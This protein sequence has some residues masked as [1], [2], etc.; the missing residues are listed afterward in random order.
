MYFFTIFPYR[1]SGKIKTLQ[2]YWASMIILIGIFYPCTRSIVCFSRFSRFSR[3]IANVIDPTWC[4]CIWRLV[5][6][7][8]TWLG[9]QWRIVHYRR[10]RESSTER[11]RYTGLMAEEKR[12]STS[13]NILSISLASMSRERNQ[14]HTEEKFNC[15][16]EILKQRIFRFFFHENIAS[17]VSKQN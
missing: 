15:I 3:R 8:G 13:G 1:I 17:S 6:L 2:E 14:V 10:G 9:G 7:N 16:K 11:A 4:S 5:T 12:T